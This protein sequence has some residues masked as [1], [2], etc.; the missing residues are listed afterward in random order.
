MLTNLHHQDPALTAQRVYAA[1]TISQKQRLGVILINIRK[2]QHLTAPML[3]EA[4]AEQNIT[5]GLSPT[6][7]ANY[8]R[9]Q[10]KWV[11]VPATAGFLKI[12]LHRALTLACTGT[13]LTPSAMVQL[14]TDPLR[15]LTM[16]ANTERALIRPWLT[17]WRQHI[18][19]W[20][21]RGEVFQRW[22]NL[23]YVPTLRTAQQFGSPHNQ[24]CWSIDMM[25]IYLKTLKLDAATLLAKALKHLQT[26]KPP[27]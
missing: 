10:P 24:K 18:L 17:Q 7:C 8:L 1:L 5:R 11:V 4:W 3:I 19:P 16:L 13:P 22:V 15:Q 23:A 9:R 6:L 26:A 27:S 12:D 14:C 25:D 21:R 20:G 2:A